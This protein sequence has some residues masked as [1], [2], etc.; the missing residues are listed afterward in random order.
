MPGGLLM[1]KRERSLKTISRG[2]TSGPTSASTSRRAPQ[3]K[4]ANE[5][6]TP[7]PV[8]RSEVQAGDS[9]YSPELHGALPKIKALLNVPD[10][11]GARHRSRVVY[12]FAGSHGL[13]AQEPPAAAVQPP[14]SLQTN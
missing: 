14:G 1:T 10:R 4:P 6:G 3:A 7:R 9:L 11:S 8:R 12:R 2:I 13:R 5:Y